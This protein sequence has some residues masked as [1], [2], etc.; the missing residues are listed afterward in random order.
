MWSQNC[1]REHFERC[2]DMYVC[3]IVVPH[4][5]REDFWVVTAQERIVIAE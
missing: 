3:M 4:G 5:M 2:R 1:Y